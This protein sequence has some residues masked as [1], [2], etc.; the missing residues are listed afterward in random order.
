M[1]GEERRHN[2]EHS[3]RS[4]QRD[5]DMSFYA[6]APNIDLFSPKCPGPQCES[7]G[8]VERS[9]GAGQAEGES[10]FR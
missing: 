10:A 1:T 2:S 8:G 6:A 3:P 9:Q 5:T 7:P 4:E